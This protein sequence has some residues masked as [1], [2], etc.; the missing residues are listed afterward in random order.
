[1][2]GE[3]SRNSSIQF[4]AVVG[5]L[6]APLDV[7]SFT[8]NAYR[9]EDEEDEDVVIISADPLGD[10]RDLYEERLQERVRS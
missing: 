4:S 7:R 10:L 1:M 9:A 3:A 2:T 6:G 5:N 8:D